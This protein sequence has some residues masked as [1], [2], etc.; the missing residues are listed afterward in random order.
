M[1]RLTCPTSPSGLSLTMVELW[2]RFLSFGVREAK[3]AWVRW[4]WVRSLAHPGSTPRVP[5]CHFVKEQGGVGVGAVGGYVVREALGSALHVIR[6]GAGLSVAARLTSLLFFLL[7]ATA[8][9]LGFPRCGW[10]LR[11]P[12][13]PPRGC[14][15]VRVTRLAGRFVPRFLPQVSGV[16]LVLLGFF[17][18]V[19]RYSWGCVGLRT[20]GRAFVLARGAATP[21]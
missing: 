13:R 11:P 8:V 9:L 18:V 7:V 3:R 12:R 14:G 20:L 2:A 16:V 4:S 19:P 5:P 10:R 15:A 1:L 6:A 17:G 21:T